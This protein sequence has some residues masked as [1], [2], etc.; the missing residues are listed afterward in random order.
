MT[1]F[2]LSDVGQKRTI[3]QD[4]IYTSITSIGL[5][6]NLFLVADGMGGHKAGDFASRKTVEIMVE[7]I[8]GNSKESPVVVLREAI[9][10]ANDAIYRLASQ[11]EDMEG[12]GTTLVAA[13]LIGDRLQVANVGDS[14]LYV[15]GEEITQ[16]TVDHSLVEEM[17]RVGTID[18]E[19]A[20]SHPRKNI[21]TRAV[22]VMP[23][24]QPDFFTV[25]IKKGEQ[26]L[27]CT[28]G[29]T[30]MLEDE[31]IS[32]I[33]KSR[34]TVEEKVKTLVAEANRRGGKD[35]ISVVLLDPAFEQNG[36]RI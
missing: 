25:T 2:S 7:E 24:I 12:M 3:N 6:P 35:N 10:K 9:E 27:L 23:T 31:E 13:S 29:L 8:E 16:I 21:I 11:D 17:V 20:K 5:L 1:V 33:V 34:G 19:M 14:R 26:V 18:K 15:I 4:F 28:D 32:K 36:E 30:N 22:G